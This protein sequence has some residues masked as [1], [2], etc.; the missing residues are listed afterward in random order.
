MPEPGGPEISTRLLAGA[1]LAMVPRSSCAAADF[2]IRP[3]GAMVWARRRRFSRFSE[4]ASNARSTTT[5]KRSDLKG[6]SMKS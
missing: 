2:P 5:T 1:T 6:F 3:V 4:A